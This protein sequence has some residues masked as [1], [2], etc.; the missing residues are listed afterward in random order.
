MKTDYRKPMT[1]EEI[2]ALRDED[3][4][5]SD[6]PPLGENFWKSARIVW[7][8]RSKKQSSNARDQDA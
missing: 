3:I 5:F 6:I 7:P 1:P 4:D 8:D 2:T